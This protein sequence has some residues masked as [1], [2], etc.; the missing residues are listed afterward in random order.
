MDERLSGVGDLSEEQ[1]RI[2]REGGTETAFGP[3]YEEFKKHGAGEYHCVGCGELLFSSAEIFDSGSGWPAFYDVVAGSAVELRESEGYRMP[4]EVVCGGCEGHLGHLFTGEGF[5]TPSDQRYCI[6]A[7]VLVYKPEL[8]GEEEADTVRVMKSDEE[9]RE[10]LDDEQFRVLREAGTE[11]PFGPAYEEFKKQGAG[12]YYCVGCDAKLFSS[13]EK[14]DSGCGWPSFFDPAK[15]ENVKTRPDYSGGR[16]RTEV[17]CARC[18]GHLGHLFT[19]EGFDTPTD[20]RYCINMVTMR[21]VP[22]E[23]GDAAAE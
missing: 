15:E 18:D 6:N 2:L 7:A 16:V 5:E 11:A 9:W 21:F 22:E 1:H 14:F 20:Q 3:A 13:N 4:K 12:T 10:M 17:L 8:E 19:G 23:A